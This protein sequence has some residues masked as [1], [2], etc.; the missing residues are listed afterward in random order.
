M[1][2]IIFLIVLLFLGWGRGNAQFE[3]IDEGDQVKII[4]IHGQDITGRVI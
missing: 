3:G 4:S 1:S 2:R